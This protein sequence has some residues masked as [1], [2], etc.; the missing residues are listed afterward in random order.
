MSW[1][2]LRR[3][4]VAAVALA[5]V[6][7]GLVVWARALRQENRRLAAELRSARRGARPALPPAARLDAPAALKKENEKLRRELEQS[8]VPQ[9]NVPTLALVPGA[10]AAAGTAIAAESAALLLLRPPPSPAP[11]DYRMRVLG[12]DGGIVWEGSG[13]RP[14]PEGTISVLWPGALAQPGRYRL[15][16][17]GPAPTDRRLATFHLTVR[18]DGAGAE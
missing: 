1:P 12:H 7:L 6:C 4:Q 10:A 2:R 5:L 8:T 13:L 9:A 16:L 17:F 14:G 3:S 15:E 18:E 11:A